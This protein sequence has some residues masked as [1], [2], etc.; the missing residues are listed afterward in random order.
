VR[1]GEIYH[2]DDATPLHGGKPKGRYVVIVTAPDDIGLDHP[3]VVVA[4]TSSPLPSSVVVALP[5]SPVG[6][7][8]TGFRRPTFAVPAWTLEVRPS[9]LGRRVG[10]L[11][12]DKLRMII[13]LLPADPEPDRP[14]TPDEISS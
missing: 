14:E 5:W 4:C 8:A 1:A 2:L 10:H 11:P 12:S 7:A 6:M 13:D 3:I 9:Q